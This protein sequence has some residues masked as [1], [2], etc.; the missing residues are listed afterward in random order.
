MSRIEELIK[1]KCPNGVEFKTI[2]E[3]CNFQNG[4]AFKSNLF[5]STGDILLRITNIDG[6]K[7]NLTDVKWEVLQ[8][9][10]NKI[11]NKEL[12]RA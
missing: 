4:Y 7:I 5:K 10:E 8:N 2:G 9:K 3:C 12:E 1:E 11:N 6:K